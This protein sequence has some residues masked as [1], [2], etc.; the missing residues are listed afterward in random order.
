VT[1]LKN[2]D[3]SGKSRIQIMLFQFWFLNLSI[4]DITVEI[5]E[6]PLLELDR[7]HRAY[8]L[9]VDVQLCKFDATSINERRFR[10]RAADYEAITFYDVIWSCFEKFVPRT[11]ARC[12]QKF[13]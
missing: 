11:S 1:L 13:P 2:D 3:L 7:H 9:L 4:T 8:E 6:S 12:A 5:C 10:F